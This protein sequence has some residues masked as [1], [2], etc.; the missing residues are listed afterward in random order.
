[1]TDTPNPC[2]VCDHERIG[3]ELNYSTCGHCG[4]RSLR[5]DRRREIAT[6]TTLTQPSAAELDQIEAAYREEGYE[7]VLAVPVPASSTAARTA[8]ETKV[9]AEGNPYARAS[10]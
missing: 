10:T 1:M 9:I 2:A 3:S 7:S 6:V 5:P 8:W 4:G